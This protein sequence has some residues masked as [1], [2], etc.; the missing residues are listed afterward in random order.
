MRCIRCR[1]ARGLTLEIRSSFLAAL[2]HSIKPR[3]FTSLSLDVSHEQTI[4]NQHTRSSLILPQSSNQTFNHTTE[5]V[6]PHSPM[7][8]DP[9][10]TQQNIISTA[11]SRIN[12]LINEKQYVQAVET[13]R[14]LLFSGNAGTLRLLSVILGLEKRAQ[15]GYSETEMSLLFSIWD[16]CYAAQIPLDWMSMYDFAVAFDQVDDTQRIVELADVMLNTRLKMPVSLDVCSLMLHL[17]V[18]HRETKLLYRLESYIMDFI[19]EDPLLSLDTLQHRGAID[20]MLSKQQVEQAANYLL[21]YARSLQIGLTDWTRV[22]TA[23]CS[24]GRVDQAFSL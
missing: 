8:D 14:E 9:I 11:K 17:L 3:P 20:S 6:R 10:L 2:S 23:L 15:S 19:Q 24:S 18:I 13:A 4:S 5:N 22:M 1:S 21:Q 16:A 7:N 12:S